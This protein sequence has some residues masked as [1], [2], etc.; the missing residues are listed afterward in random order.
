MVSSLNTSINNVYSIMNQS[1]ASMG[2]VDSN[3]AATIGGDLQRGIQE[4]ESSREKGTTDA[5]RQTLY[6]LNVL[7]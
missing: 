6:K 7:V 1:N 4:V 3:K 5:H 2:N